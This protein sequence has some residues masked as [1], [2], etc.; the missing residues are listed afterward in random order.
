MVGFWQLFNWAHTIR[1]FQR[2][3]KGRVIAPRRIRIERPR[4]IHVKGS[5]YFG[6]NLCVMNRAELV[7]GRN[8]SIGPNVCFIDYNHDYKSPAF[9]PYSA[10]NLVAPIT[11]GEHV[12]IGFGAIILPGVSIGDGAI[13]GA[14]SVVNHDVPPC[15]IVAGNPA[16]QVSGRNQEAFRELQN[17]PAA[18]HIDV[19]ARAR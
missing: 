17:D 3:G 12:W 15:S 5:I 16:V 8:V 7:F 2:S 14:G 1:R 9:L 13:V 4:L 19:Q 18:F 6:P 10:E 11:V